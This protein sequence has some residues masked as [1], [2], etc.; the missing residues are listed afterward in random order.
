MIEVALYQ[1]PRTAE[2]IIGVDTHKDQHVAVAIDGRGVRLDEKYVPATTRGYEELEGW[3]RSL[4]VPCAF[5]A[6]GTGSYGAGVA[7]FHPLIRSPECGPAESHTAV[8]TVRQRGSCHRE[9]GPRH[10]G[11]DTECPSSPSSSTRR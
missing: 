9:A 7:R 8:K 11:V 10:T 3:S 1:V 4:G 5:G 6:E 2:V